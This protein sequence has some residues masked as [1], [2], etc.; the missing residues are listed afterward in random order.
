MLGPS[1]SQDSNFSH[2]GLTRFSCRERQTLTDNGALLEHNKAPSWVQRSRAGSAHLPARAF[3][4]PACST[5]VRVHLWSKPAAEQTHPAIL[6]G[7]K[8]QLLLKQCDLF[9]NC[10][11][12][13]N[14]GIGSA[15]ETTFKT[16]T[17]CSFPSQHRC[18]SAHPRRSCRLWLI[19]SCQGSTA[20]TRFGKGL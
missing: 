4:F 17:R 7:T 20:D 19:C 3:H 12:W 13:H 1:L 10:T 8:W 15:T 6:Y 16:C 2:W 9:Q 18:T 11:G 5:E 14:A